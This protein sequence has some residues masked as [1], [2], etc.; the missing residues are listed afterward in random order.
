[1]FLESVRGLV[2]SGDTSAV[3]LT[4]NVRDVYA[5][6]GKFGTLTELLRSQVFSGYDTVAEYDPQGG[7]QFADAKQRENYL[8]ALSGYDAYHK[9]SY[10]QNPP[11]DPVQAFSILDNFARLHLI[12]KKS[13]CVIIHYLDQIIPTGLNNNN[14]L[15]YLVIALDK[16]AQNLDFR[17]NKIRFVLIAPEVA[18]LESFIAKNAFIEHVTIA[19]PGLEERHNTISISHRINSVA[20]GEEQS[21]RLAE[22]TAGLTNRQVLEILSK[23]QTDEIQLRAIKKEL[24]SAECRGLLEIV[25][26]KHSLSVVAGHEKVKDILSL[27]AE[28]IKLGKTQYLPMGFLICGPVGTGKTFITECFAHDAALP[29]VKFLNF[30][31]QW[32]GETEANLEKI[33]NILKSIYPVA[34]MIDEAD[35]FLGNRD[36][37]GDSGVSMRVFASLAALMSDTSYRGKIIWFLM[38]SRPDL[39]P[40]DMKRQGRAEEHLALFHP[41]SGAE[42][43]A[44]YTSVC[45][46][47]KIASPL[48]ELHPL[49]DKKRSYSGADIEAMMTRA[50]LSAAVRHKTELNADIV[51]ETITNFRSPEYPLAIEL[52]TL[53]AVRECT[54]QDMVPEKYRGLAAADIEARINEL[55]SMLRQR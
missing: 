11:K 37:Q 1:M 10:A 49:L 4:G 16:W 3:M 48:E 26:P 27:T 7:I 28:A 23:K 45:K 39:L 19:R 51:K 6:D 20:N 24:I 21:H 36:A 50:A 31:S 40:V 14:E 9:T 8:R 53:V 22:L 30:R 29:V 18:R 47:L 12:D 15:R 42:V 33:F 46:R 54:H 32:Q 5:F 13:F 43:D 34:V 41:Q 55:L 25:E 52:Q 35:A 44:L 2:E 38:T 17:R